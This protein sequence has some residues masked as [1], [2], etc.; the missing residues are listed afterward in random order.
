MSLLLGISMGDFAGIG[1][2]VTL[3]ALAAE[4]GSDDARFE[5]IGDVEQTQELN[6]RLGLN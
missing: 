2:E 5:L 3:K 1:P 6:R 4:L